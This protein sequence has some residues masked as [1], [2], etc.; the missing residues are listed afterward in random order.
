VTITRARERERERERDDSYAGETR[1]KS[2]FP[3]ESLIEARDDAL[4]ATFAL[5]SPRGPSTSSGVLARQRGEAL[6]VRLDV[7]GDEADE[8]KRRRR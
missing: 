4:S 8:K 2:S 3:G 1:A 7:Y 6:L 5:I